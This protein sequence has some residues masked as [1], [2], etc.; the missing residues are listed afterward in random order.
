MCYEVKILIDMKDSVVTEAISSTHC[1]ELIEFLYI[2]VISICSLYILATEYADGFILH[3]FR[4]ISWRLKALTNYCT[5][6]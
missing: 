3:F 2:F 5:V 1:K 6:L 4:A